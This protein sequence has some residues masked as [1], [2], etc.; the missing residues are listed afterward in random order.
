MT[1]STTGAA[2]TP[3]LATPDALRRF[4]SEVFFVEGFSEDA[5]FLGEGIIDSTG[6]LELV[7]FVETTYGLQILDDELV[8]ENFDSLNKVVA[9]I[10][11]KT[12]K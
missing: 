8:P 11:R 12:V 6:M 7:M 5:S 4:I 9:F 10:T 1:T 2:M 3:I